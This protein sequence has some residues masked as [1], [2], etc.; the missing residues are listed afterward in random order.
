LY[1]T[2]RRDDEDENDFRSLYHTVA[3]FDKTQGLDPEKKQEIRDMHPI[4]FQGDTM[5]DDD[6]MF[7]I[8]GLSLSSYNNTG[9][10]SSSSSSS[11][12]EE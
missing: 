7:M 1:I 9:I 5:S 4:K 3:V 10:T 2:T 12:D 8:H 6:L 11:E